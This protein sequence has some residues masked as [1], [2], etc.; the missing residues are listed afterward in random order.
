MATPARYYDLIREMR[1]AYNHR[2]RL[3]QYARQ[4]GLKPTA[5]AFTTTV[6][7]VRKWWRRY[8]QHGLEG[9]K[10]LSRAPHH[11]PRQTPQTIQEQVLALRRRLPTVGAARLKR[12][13][14]LRPSQ[15]AV[16]GL[17][18]QILQGKLCIAPSAGIHQVILNESC[19]VEAF[20]E[21]ANEQQTA[22]GGHP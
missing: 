1:D 11:C 7:T 12:E 10:E 3:V 22:V 19:Q 18:E 21:F 2:L 20:I 6:P 14:D 17:S 4:H 15:S 8:H 5:R 16:G 13:F 9:L